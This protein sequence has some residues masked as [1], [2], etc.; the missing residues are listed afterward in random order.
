MTRSAKH[1][2]PDRVAFDIDGVV[3]D[4]VTPFLRLLEERYGYGGFTPED[5]TGFDLERALKIPGEVVA[6]IVDDLINR[7]VELGAKPYPGA[8][9][10]LKQLSLEAPL[11]FVTSRP[12]PDP[13][14]AWF[15]RCL[16]DLPGDRLEIIATGDPATKLDHLLEK[17]RCY[18]VEDYLETCRQLE[19]AGLCPIVFDQPWNRDDGAFLRVRNWQELGR[20]FDLA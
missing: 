9:E 6:D 14:R 11:L 13:I 17:G 2:E 10:V 7:P 8:A 4:I 3:L 5:V 19:R 15:D 20:L 1:L 12:W 18:F 16:P